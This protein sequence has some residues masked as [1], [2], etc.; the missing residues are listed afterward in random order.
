MNTKKLLVISSLFTSGLF[1]GASAHALDYFEGIAA[2]VAMSTG[3]DLTS[4]GSNEAKL[5]QVEA[6]RFDATEYWV[7]EAT[8]PSPSLKFFLAD[9]HKQIAAR[10]PELDLG[11]IDDRDLAK[12]ILK[13][14]PQ[15]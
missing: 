2:S 11:K 9:M 13:D 7:G 3:F 4:D 12:E 10:H 6:L 8:V 5:A 14:L 1:A 15:N